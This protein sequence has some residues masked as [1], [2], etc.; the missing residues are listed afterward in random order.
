MLWFE[1]ILEHL[2]ESFLR[3]LRPKLIQ[4]FLPDMCVW[5]VGIN[6]KLTSRKIGHCSKV[7][8]L[9]KIHILAK[10]I[11]WIPDWFNARMK[12][13]L[14]RV[15]LFRQACVRHR[16]EFDHEVEPLIR[17]SLTLCRDAQA[18]G[19]TAPPFFGRSVKFLYSNQRRPNYAHHITACNP[20]FRHLPESLVWKGCV[21]AFN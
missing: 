12:V 18:G 17:S 9:Y 5:G 21:N 13:N 15:K 10:T 1:T 2:A 6:C 19:A 3:S 14:E 8:I 20:K 11:F 16:D 4:F 7:W